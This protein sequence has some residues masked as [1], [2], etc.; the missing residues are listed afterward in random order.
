[1]PAAYALV[2]VNPGAES[3]VAAPWTNVA[4]VLMRR[5]D[6]TKR[7]GTSAFATANVGPYEHYQDVPLP[8][9]ETALVDT[10]TRALW[11]TGYGMTWSGST[12][13]LTMYVKALDALGA[14]LATWS[15]VIPNKAS[16]GGTANY[17]SFTI[18]GAALP[19]GT[20][21]IRVGWTGAE[22]AVQDIW[23]DDLSATIEDIA[24]KATKLNSYVVRGPEPQQLSATKE[25]SYVVRGPGAPGWV[26]A[27][28]L[29]TYGVLANTPRLAMTKG[30]TYLVLASTR[31]LG[32]YDGVAMVCADRPA[33]TFSACA[34]RPES[35]A[36]ACATRPEANSYRPGEQTFT[37]ENP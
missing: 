33:S 14:V 13:T 5:T 31:P 36:E 28:K 25:A 4:N 26:S 20:R 34:T 10:G 3:P 27:T 15:Q 2:I 9:G 29:V 30:T 21:T 35:T 6:N 32:G 8:A 23:V 17:G 19:V 11:F 1:M 37:R 22:A 18:L 12:S 24:V 7:S 16:S